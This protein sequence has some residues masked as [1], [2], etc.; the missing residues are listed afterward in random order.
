VLRNLEAAGYTG[1]LYPVNP[2][3]SMIHGRQCLASVDDLPQGVDCAVLAIPANAVLEAAAACA[4][5]GVRSLIAFS[6][7][8][9]ES[10]E[11]GRSVQRELERIAGEHSMIIEGPNCLGLVNYVDRIPLTFIVTQLPSRSH[12]PGVAIISQSGALAAVL[13]VNM[14]HHGITLSYS[15]STGN[16]VALGVEDAVEHFI[17]DSHTYVMALVVE[18][19]RQPK[20][21]LELARRAREA[22]KFMVLLH[23]GSS[24]AARASATTHTGAMA[25]N[26]DVMRVFVSRQGAVSVE[27][28]EELVDVCQ[29]LVRCRTLPQGGT[30]IF[31]ESGAF[32]A[33]ALDLCE[34]IGLELPPLIGR[35]YERMRAALPEFIPPSNPLDVTAQGLVDPGLYRRTLPPI[36]EDE[37]FGSVVLDIILTDSTTTGLKL[38]PILDSLRE[39]RPEKP[40]IFAAMDEGA[41]TVS[42]ALNELR[43]LGVACFPSPERALRALAH[44]TALATKERK[45]KLVQTEP[46]QKGIVVQAG[47]LPEYRSKAILAKL[48]VPVP[49]GGLARSL[50]EAFLIAQKIGFPVALKA[51]AADL[52]HKS[53]AGGVALSIAGKEALADG[54]AVLYR[55]LATHKPG[56]VLDGVL[57]ERMSEKGVELIVGARNDPDWGPVLLAGFGGVLAEVINDRRLMPPDLSVDEICEELERLRCAPL[58]RGFRGSP[59]L[60]VRAAAEI[61]QALGRLMLAV[62]AIQEVDINPV[63][64][65]PHG[66]VALDALIINGAELR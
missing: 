41:P 34:R 56:L 59:P 64:V 63:V 54:W 13:A 29:V 40:V 14:Q 39:L 35:S 45:R 38:P 55:N 25:G 16:E 42:V 23:P 3:R 33:L 18:Q 26:Y 5:R 65:Y 61:V 8:F 7:G 60:D 30:A 49:E 66:A 2:K 43:Q 11:A 44:V 9:A 10:G 20:R 51:Q 28:M 15:I 58:L 31:A 24:S 52:P 21:F 4:R 50:D 46:A 57:V 19:F 53:N 36:I 48:G 6:A 1:E 62:P 37:R 32:K 17:A 22:G 12:A 27:S 47:V